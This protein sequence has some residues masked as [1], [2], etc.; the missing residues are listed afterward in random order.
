MKFIKKLHVPFYFNFINTTNLIIDELYLINDDKA[1]LKQKQIFLQ[2]FYFFAKKENEKN[3]LMIKKDNN[4]YVKWIN[5]ALIIIK[6]LPNSKEKLEEFEHSIKDDVNLCNLYANNKSS[7]FLKGEPTILQDLN[8]AINYYINY[9]KDGEEW[10]EAEDLFSKDSYA[11]FT[12]AE[13]TKKLFPKGEDA[14]SKNEKY[15]IKYA[16]IFKIRF[17]KCE[18]L[19]LK[20]K[21]VVNIIEYLKILKDIGEDWNEGKE[22]LLSSSLGAYEYC[23]EILEGRDSRAEEIILD[24]INKDPYYSY[25]YVRDVIKGRWPKAEKKILNIFIKNHKKNNEENDYDIL[26]NYIK[27]VNERVLIFEPY[28]IKS[29]RA[30][31]YAIN[32]IKDRWPELEQRIKK[33]NYDEVLEYVRF[34]GYTWKE[35]EEIIMSKDQ[36]GKF[37]NSTKVESYIRDVINNK[38]I[39]P[40]IKSIIDEY[41]SKTEDKNIFINDIFYKIKMFSHLNYFKESLNKNMSKFIKMIDINEFSYKIIKN[42]LDNNINVEDL[43]IKVDLL[44]Y[45]LYYHTFYRSINDDNNKLLDDVTSK[46]FSNALKIIKEKKLYKYHLVYKGETL[47]IIKNNKIVKKIIDLF[48]EERSKEYAYL[49][50]PENIKRINSI[51]D[52]KERKK[53]IEDNAIL[54]KRTLSN[55]IKY[56]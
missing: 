24:F 42:R 46:S 50:G 4:P 49:N 45:R 1:T 53:E 31:N 48:N 8:I 51:E 32:T 22:E 35:A 33:F 17:K 2:N 41:F 29:V 55:I 7:R 39:S 30:M 40:Y 25:L 3:K 9:F 38:N 27:E 28:L 47:T 13:K 11:S 14:I 23:K 56:N 44:I 43:D 37:I 54:V 16:K 36:E 15:S 20:N 10:K 5:T 52:D 6:L 18:E 34:T 21:Y 26:F 12:Y 19:L